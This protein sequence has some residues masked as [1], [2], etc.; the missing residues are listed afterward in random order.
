MESK[1]TMD[2]LVVC[3]ALIVITDRIGVSRSFNV[4]TAGAKI[5][6]GPPVEEF[7]YTVQQASNHEGK[8]LLVGA[9]W[10]GY[11]QNRKGDLYKCPVSGARTTCDKLNIEDSINIP[12]VNN[13]NVNMSLGMTLTR[14]PA[15]NGLM[16]C[17]P[18]WAQRCGDQN[19]YP[20]ICSRLSPLFQPQPAF[21]PAVQTCGG[22]MDIVIVLDGSNSI[23][24]WA[25][26]TE[27]IEKLL[28]TLEIGPQNTQVSVIQYAVN[29]KIEFPLNQYR[30]RAELLNAAS[31][32]KQMQGSS[33]N[34]FHAIQYASQ[35][36]FNPIY[37]ARP[38]ASKVMVV[39]TDGESHDQAFRDTVI[40]EC[41]KQGITR[42]GI[43]VLGYYT[44]NNIDTDNLIKEI[45]SIASAP[46][47]NYF[48]N[49]SEEAALSNI[50]GTLG[51][52]IFNI[53]GTGKGGDNFNMEMSQVGFSAHS[54]SKKDMTMLGAV[55]A[56]GWA[57]TVVHQMGSKVDVLPVSAFEGTLQDRNHSSLLGY[58]VCMLSDGATEYFVAGA[59]RSNH[60]GQVIVY[61]YNAQK[62]FTIVDSERGKQIGSY[63]G[64]VL[65]ALDVDKD[66]VTDLLLVSAPMFMSEQ[67]R[68][69]GRVYIF[70]V[71]KGILNE[72]GFLQG[73]PPAENGRFGTAAS[74][75]PDLD[76]DGYNDV[77]VGAPLEDKGRG[78]L[79]IYNGRKK[80][81][82]KQFSQR[83]YGSKMDPQVKFFGRSL[84]SYKDLNDDTLA[85]ISV[86]AYGKVVQLWSR[87]V[88]TLSATASFKPEKIDI[89]SKS[90]DVNGRKMTCF[91]SNLCF[92]PTFRPQN[93]VGPMDL[94][95]T[96]TLD[97][98]LQASRVTSRGLFMKN[99]ERV[100]TENAKISTGIQCQDFQVYVQETP[101]FV[102]SVSLKVEIEQRN[103]DANPVLDV[104]ST[105]AWEFFIPFTK[106]CGSDEVCV[107]D[108]VL[109]VKTDTEGTSSA[110]FLV[111]TNKQEL[112]FEVTVKNKKENAYNTQVLAAYSANLF[113]S[114]VFPPTEGVKC[115]STQEQT[116]VCQVGYPALKND[117][118]MK[119]QL[120]FQ[121]NLNHP[122]S[123]AKVKF[124]AKSDGKEQV[125]S[126][127]RV[128]VSI[129]LQYDA[130]VVLSRNS[131]INFYVANST[132][133]PVTTVKTLDDIGPEFNFTVKVS[134][135]NFP[136]SLL[137]LTVSLPM[138]TKGGNPLLYLTSVDTQ[139]GGAVSCDS[140][141]LADPL[142]IGVKD[143][144][145]SFTEESLRGVEKL[146]CQSAKC[147]KIKCLLKDAEVSSDYYVKVKTR[148]WSGTFIT[149]LYQTTEL[150]STVEVESSNPD[151]FIIRLKEL[152]VVVTVSKPGA[153]GDVP[154]GVIVGS[155][156][157]GLV[158]LGL[159]VALLWKFGF[160]KRKYQQLQKDADAQSHDDGVL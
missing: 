2:Y 47:E 48:F 6:S 72:Q 156:I 18:L 79:Y 53:E 103:A 46:T 126:D 120:N 125:P 12:D 150:I 64:G 160:F 93:P 111:S 28:P 90:C 13:V 122:L 153:T 31:Q 81:L 147:Q 3:F 34:T 63:F 74:A 11:T 21:A 149:A 108:L 54:S 94:T 42:F 124:E 85:D 71:T 26:M 114:S 30:T 142:R 82:D 131:N 41:E 119:F 91:N 107:S 139:V 112:S 61:S 67:K 4:G 102:N 40:A 127:N 55:G 113:Y 116:V 22:P 151:L 5:F 97:A 146:D 88:A 78:V 145:A 158:L 38:T 10:S 25:P 65:C 148:I 123:R 49:V 155:V 132:T 104:F 45:K 135:G 137:Y 96:L 144:Q 75:I 24:P 136:V 27:F 100:F 106:N 39:V 138:S 117:Q 32:L 92:S 141:G 80:T 121:Y 14:L 118:M 98:D 59:P 56:Y 77:V 87:G 159:A 9:P 16:T 133:T 44:R 157:G 19:Y 154:V 43:A 1:W 57:G 35:W 99:N 95:Y 130:G 51:S 129:P 83:I 134:T 62:R 23:Y 66:G 86:G 76:L 140:V 68:E 60:S 15:V 37:G 36:G 143:H 8:W 29:P 101:D 84:D 58:S 7:G 33:T 52:R 69:Q 17:G 89:F 105:S 110:P 128:D 20:G 50:A 109:S 152:P 73:T 115:T 70:T